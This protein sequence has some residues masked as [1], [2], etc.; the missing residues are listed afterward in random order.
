MRKTT[1]INLKQSKKVVVW[2]VC[3]V[4]EG[5]I[6]DTL[7]DCDYEHKKDIVNGLMDLVRNPQF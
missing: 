7:L 4:W 2:C 5:I 3:S 6:N 1:G